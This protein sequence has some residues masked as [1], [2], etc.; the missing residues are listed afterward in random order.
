MPKQIMLTACI[1]VPDDLF[2]AATV[3]VSVKDKWGAMLDALAASNIVHDATAEYTEAKR[4]PAPKKP[5]RR[6]AG[7]RVQ[8]VVPSTTDLQAE[9]LP[10]EE[11]T[12]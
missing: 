2:E 11:V 5:Q 7:A 6:A 4:G 8:P 10:L 3:A 1:D 12:N 9:A